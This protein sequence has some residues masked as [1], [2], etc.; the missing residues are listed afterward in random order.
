MDVS[1][2]LGQYMLKGW[3][4]YTYFTNWTSQRTCTQ[5]LT[6]IICAN[7]GSVPKMRSPT[8]TT[9]VV[10]LCVNCDDDSPKPQERAPNRDSITS[11]DLSSLATVSRTSTPPTEVSSTLSSPTFALPVDTEAMLRRRQQSDRAST[12]IG[13]RLLKGWAM[14][15]DECPNESCF[16][17]PL[18]RPPKP[19]GGKDPRQVRCSHLTS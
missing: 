12:E 6:D 10:E 16:G 2:K 8:G 18:V 11:S 4:R 7:C 9:P 17:V 5:V 19:G 14:L 15:A 3:V 1:P 13:N